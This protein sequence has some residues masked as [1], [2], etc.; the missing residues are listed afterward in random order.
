MYEVGDLGDF[1]DEWGNW[2]RGGKWRE[3]GN[4]SRPF[5]ESPRGGGG[6]GESSRKK[7]ESLVSLRRRRRLSGTRGGWWATKTG[8]AVNDL[9]APAAPKQ[10]SRET[11]TALRW[12]AGRACN[13]VRC[14]CGAVR[15]RIGRTVGLSLPWCAW[16]W[17]RRRRRGGDGGGWVGAGAPDGSQGPPDPALIAPISTAYGG[18][19]R[20]QVIGARADP[21]SSQQQPISSHQLTI[22]GRLATTHLAFLAPPLG[23]AAVGVSLQQAPARRRLFP[24]P[25]STILHIC[26]CPHFF[27]SPTGGKKI[28][29]SPPSPPHWRS[30]P[31]SSC[32]LRRLGRSKARRRCPP[33]EEGGARGRGE[34]CGTRCGAIGLSRKR[35]G[36][37]SDICIVLGEMPHSRGNQHVCLLLAAKKHARNLQ[38]TC[39]TYVRTLPGRLRSFCAAGPSPP[40]TLCKD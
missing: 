25:S 27:F 33:G 32:H 4:K 26:E 14:G 17:R 19:A 8:H 24:C 22:P 12:P 38:P 30:W 1:F 5:A 6:G 7:R 21:G 10:A 31:C 20:S 23:P 36:G 11:S 15:V 9:T 28:L 35:G 40:S 34:S 3:I 29:S 13:P 2:A 37:Q 18:S 16:S 39:Q